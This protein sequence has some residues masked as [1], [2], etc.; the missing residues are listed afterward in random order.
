MNKKRE[1]RAERMFGSEPRKSG[2]NARKR[3]KR[4]KN[5]LTEEELAIWNTGYEYRQLRRAAMRNHGGNGPQKSKRDKLHWD[6]FQHP[7]VEVRVTL[8]QKS[9]RDKLDWD[10]RGPR[11]FQG[12]S[13]GLGKRK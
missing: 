9:K 12:G 5:A 13:P 1:K 10:G 2:K 3:A 11:F 4:R 6:G 8:P 7:H